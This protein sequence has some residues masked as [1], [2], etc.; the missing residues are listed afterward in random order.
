[1]ES[2]LLDSALVP[3]RDLD[4]LF[5][6]SPAAMVFRDRELRARRTNAAFRRLFGLPDEAVIGRRPSEVDS[7][8]DAALLERILAEQVIGRGV[9]V[10]DMPLE[11]GLAG[12]R[13]VLSWS[14]YPV[15]DNGQV[16]GALCCFGDVTGQ[17]SS[18]L[19]AH[20]LLE[21]AGHQIGTTLDVHRTAAE[22]A[23]L[24][25]PGLADRIAID[26]LD[27][28]LQGE[29][30]PAPTRAPCSSAGWRCATP[31]GPRLTSRWVT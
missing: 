28:V 14:A 12:K 8:V 18:L 10:T 7:G 5:G 17:V 31:R 22:L 26:L 27:Q 24:A 20:A 9:P 3:L 16:L 29:T 19:Q 15:T 13:R 23:D 1:M 4:A 30:F 2:S 6:Q 21:R 11:Q 25:V